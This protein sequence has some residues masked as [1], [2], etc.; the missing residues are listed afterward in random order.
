MGLSVVEDHIIFIV[1]C[2]PLFFSGA[3]TSKLLHNLGFHQAK[4]FSNF[5]SSTGLI[6]DNLINF[7]SSHDYKFGDKMISSLSKNAVGVL[8]R[9]FASKEFFKKTAELN[10]YFVIRISKSYK[11]KFVKNSE[12]IKVGAGKNSGLY[13]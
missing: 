13:R 6:N 4:L 12:E 3:V 11:L 2:F 7:G 8:D 1:R 9:G 10:K 5:N